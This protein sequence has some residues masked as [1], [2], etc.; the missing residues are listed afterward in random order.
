MDSKIHVM[1]STKKL[2]V[3]RLDVCEIFVREEHLLKMNCSL[4]RHVTGTVSTLLIRVTANTWIL[5]LSDRTILTSNDMRYRTITKGF[6]D[7]MQRNMTMDMIFL[8]SGPHSF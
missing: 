5:N 6:D 4:A 8:D 2:V 3:M 1:L 7:K